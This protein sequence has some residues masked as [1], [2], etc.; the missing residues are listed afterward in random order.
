MLTL[1]QRFIEID[2]KRIEYS[3]GP[4]VAEKFEQAMKILFQTPKPEAEPKKQRTPA[5][6]VRKTEDADRD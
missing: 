5:S 2:M 4:E 1:T 3:K 6:S